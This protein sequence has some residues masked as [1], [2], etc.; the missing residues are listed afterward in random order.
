MFSK[1]HQIL[2]KQKE[3]K[4]ISPS[5]T[6]AACNQKIVEALANKKPYFI[7]RLGWMEG[8]AIGQLLANA[9][10]TLSLRE[11]LALHAGVFPPTEEQFKKFADIYLEAMSNVDIFGLMEAPFHGWLIKKYA[12]QAACAGLG[13]LE[14]YFSEEP[15]SWQL[16]GL[17][18]LVVHPFSESI[19]KQYSTVRAQ[20][21]TNPKMLPEFTLKVIKAPQTITGNATE[22]NC[23]LETLEALGKKI[24]QEKFDV[25]IIGCGA[26]GLPLG[27]M[28]K[29]MG[30]VAIHLGGATQL[31]FGVSGNRWR[32]HPKFKTIITSAWQAPLESER[33]AGWKKVEDGC[34]W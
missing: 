5:L 22:Y 4:K 7:G 1:V 28:I 3:Q 11:K 21:F 19:M 18:V 30:R 10:T 12:S 25:V 33:P 14:P 17:T 8:Y 23:W 2:S 9:G 34:Y 24:Q 15:W 6:A 16:K 27:T 31:L 13:S 20:L 26:Y 32:H 29:K